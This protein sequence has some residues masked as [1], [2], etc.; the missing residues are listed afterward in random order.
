MEEGGTLFQPTAQPTTTVVLHDFRVL[1]QSLRVCKSLKTWSG[2]AVV[3]E[4]AILW[5]L[6]A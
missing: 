5:R 6:A 3:A 4:V 1:W 2:G